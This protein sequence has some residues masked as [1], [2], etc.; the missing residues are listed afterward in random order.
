MIYISKCLL[1]IVGELLCKH[2]WVVCSLLLY[3]LQLC[4]I[5]STYYTHVH[6]LYSKYTSTHCST[7]TCRL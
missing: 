1:S 4:D 7:C 3:N 6:T 5:S 2:T